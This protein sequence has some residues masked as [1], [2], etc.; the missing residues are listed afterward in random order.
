MVRT[1]NNNYKVLSVKNF[2]WEFSPDLTEERLTK[3]ATFIAMVRDEVIE[4]HDEVLGDT[5]L[6]LGMRTYEC[7]RTRIIDES[8]STS[9]PWL[10]ILTPDGRFTFCIGSVPVRFTRNDPMYLP[11]RKLIV[12]ESTMEQM[13]LFGEQPHADIRWF[14]VFDTYYKNAADAVYFVGY[15][16]TGEIICQWQIPIEDNVS[17]MSPVSNSLPPAVQLERPSITLKQPGKHTYITKNE[18]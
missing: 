14:F 2:P 7:C 17:L 11:D 9:F 18:N 5:R 1:N 13:A 8:S 16:E 12:S 4:L 10:S 3:T 15:S 6:A